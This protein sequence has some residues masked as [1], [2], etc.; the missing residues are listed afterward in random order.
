MN[1]KAFAS[2]LFTFFV[3]FIN[4]QNKVFEK[5]EVEATTN[6]KLWNEHMA[7]Y[8]Q[9]PDSVLKNIPPG[10]YLVSVQFI[11]DIHGSLGQ[12]E[13]QNDPGYGLAKRAMKAVE[14]YKGE[15]KPAN[16]CGRNVKAYRKQEFTFVIPAQ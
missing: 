6:Q 13:T 3:T 10:T 2:I 12:I 11:I 4:A 8:S 15:W 5:V 16:Q 1:R 9:L 14:T 7:R